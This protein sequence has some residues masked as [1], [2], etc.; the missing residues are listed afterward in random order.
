MCTLTPYITIYYMYMYR[1]TDK[2]GVK[3]YFGG[4]SIYHYRTSCKNHYILY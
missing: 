1:Y 4:Y 2:K 3:H